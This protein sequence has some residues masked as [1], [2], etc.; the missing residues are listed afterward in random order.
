MLTYCGVM[1]SSILQVRAQFPPV[2]PQATTG[3]PRHRRGDGVGVHDLQSQSHAAADFAL[4][5]LVVGRG[6]CSRRSS[7]CALVSVVTHLS[8]VIKLIVLSQNEVKTLQMHSFDRLRRAHRTTS[9]VA[10]LDELAKYEDSGATSASLPSN[11][12]NIFEHDNFRLHV[13]QPRIDFDKL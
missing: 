12:A 2:M 4:A 10:L 1:S 13:T 11:R 8:A 7:Q 6:L 5:P 3:A 9:R